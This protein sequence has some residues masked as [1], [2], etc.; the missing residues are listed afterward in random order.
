[1][2]LLLVGSFVCFKMFCSY[3]ESCRCWAVCQ[4]RW[5][6]GMVLYFQLALFGGSNCVLS[7]SHVCCGD[8]TVLMMNHTWGTSWLIQSSRKAP[9]TFIFLFS[10]KFFPHSS[11]LWIFQAAWLFG[12]WLFGVTLWMLGFGRGAHFFQLGIRLF[13]QKTALEAGQVWSPWTLTTTLVLPLPPSKVLNDTWVSFP[14]WSE[15]ST[16]VSSK[17]TQYEEHI[18]RCEDERF[19]VNCFSLVHV[20]ESS[21][22]WTVNEPDVVIPLILHLLLCLPSC[23]WHKSLLSLL[24]KTPY[25]H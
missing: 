18:Y 17:K 20:S 8:H 4:E 25:N 14:S 22:L 10:R 13:H 16:F 15:D 11:S 19:E 12:F 2:R 9:F 3:I 6:W 24:F 5:C 7:D 21:V 23:F 1:M